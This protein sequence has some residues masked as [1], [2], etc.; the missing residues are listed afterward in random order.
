MSESTREAERIT[1]EVAKICGCVWSSCTRTREATTDA[2]DKA[3][4]ARDERAAKIVEAYN[5]ETPHKHIAA[6]I[7]KDDDAQ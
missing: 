5:E 6:A 2:I 7:R 3:L 1:L 4:R